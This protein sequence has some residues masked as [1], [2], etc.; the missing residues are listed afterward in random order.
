MIYY[1]NNTYQYQIGDHTIEFTSI[2]A[3]FS[4]RV[5]ASI[6][7]SDNPYFLE[8][9][10]NK[11]TKNKYDIEQ[12][13]AGIIINVIFSALKISGTIKEPSDIPDKIE[14]FREISNN[15]L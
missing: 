4:E 13:E 2:P 6:L 15:S 5:T 7:E 10:F 14:K 11:I 12:F 3:E 1:G 9:L 8:F